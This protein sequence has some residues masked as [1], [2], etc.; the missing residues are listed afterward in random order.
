MIE[1]PCDYPVKIMGPHKSGFRRKILD[2]VRRHAPDFLEEGLQERQ[3][4]N[5]KY[6][7]ITVTIQATGEDQLAALWQ[8]LKDSGHV[9]LV[10]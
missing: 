5:G 6:L 9:S 2:I 10:L 4:R 1:F 7:S 3:S 8:D